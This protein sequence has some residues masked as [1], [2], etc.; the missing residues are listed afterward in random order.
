MTI[1]SPEGMGTVIG[2]SL[3]P[4]A[5]LINHSCEPNSAVFFEGPELRLRSGQAIAPGEEIT[6]SYID[7]NQ[8]FNVRQEQLA[9]KYHFT[10]KCKKCKKGACRPGD[11]ITGDSEV[12][13]SI[14]EAQHQLRTLL[15]LKPGAQP[16]EA[17]KAT[18]HQICAKGYPGKSWPCDISPTH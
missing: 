16:I 10:Y 18:A 5:A 9:S 3:D 12:D 4:F 11:L 15:D 1:E 2:S 7:P 6:I 13:S 17:I 8:S 14:K